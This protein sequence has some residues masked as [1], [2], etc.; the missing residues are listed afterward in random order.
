MVNIEAIHRNAMFL[1]ARGV[2]ILD[3]FFIVYCARVVLF[4]LFST[5]SHAL[6]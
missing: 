6:D 4:V 5:P 2:T 3:R 1:L